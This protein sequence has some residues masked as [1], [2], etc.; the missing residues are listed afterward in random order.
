MQLAKENRKFQYNL[1]RKGATSALFGK[2]LEWLVAAG[3]ALRCGKITSPDIPLKAYEA[4]SSFKLYL[5][6]SG[7]L[8]EMSGL[9]REIVLNQIG[10][11]FMGGF[12]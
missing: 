3:F 4:L 1:I 10:E 11:R 12:D 7:L 5:L 9:P 8:V 6:D 2:S